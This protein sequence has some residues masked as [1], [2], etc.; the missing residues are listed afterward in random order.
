MNIAWQLKF[1]GGIKNIYFQSLANRSDDFD[2]TFQGL[3]IL[4]KFYHRN[5]VKS[6]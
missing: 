6:Y 1:I 2:F 3:N 5:F 4:K